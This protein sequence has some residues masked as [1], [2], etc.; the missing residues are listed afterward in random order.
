MASK[1]NPVNSRVCSMIC[2]VLHR[3]WCHSSTSL[4]P[5]VWNPTVTVNSPRKGTVIRKVSSCPDLITKNDTLAHCISVRTVF[6]SQM[7]L[8]PA[9]SCLDY[10]ESHSRAIHSSHVSRCRSWCPGG[11][12]IPSVRVN[13]YLSITAAYHHISLLGHTLKTSTK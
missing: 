3:R 12:P 9:W 10:R 6:L 11:R 13:E 5:C 8:W 1:K 2:S 4:S 7:I